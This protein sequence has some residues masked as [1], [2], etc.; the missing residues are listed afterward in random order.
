MELL[1][2]WRANLKPVTQKS[3]AMKKT[4]VNSPFLWVCVISMPTG[5]WCS[6]LPEPFCSLKFERKCSSGWPCTRASNCHTLW[7]TLTKENV[8]LFHKHFQYLSNFILPF[9][10]S[11]KCLI[12]TK[13]LC[14]NTLNK[15]LESFVSKKMPRRAV[16]LLTYRSS[17]SCE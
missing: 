8:L 9:R 11:P 1:N 3:Y 13:T 4:S 5:N 10:K 17:I 16:R 7:V 12:V 15:L 2:D 6:S 14:F